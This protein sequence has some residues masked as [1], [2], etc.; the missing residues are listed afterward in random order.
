MFQKQLE[1]QNYSVESVTLGQRLYMKNNNGEMQSHH[2]K[3]YMNFILQDFNLDENRLGELFTLCWRPNLYKTYSSVN[4]SDLVKLNSKLINFENENSIRMFNQGLA[5]GSFLMFWAGLEAAQHCV[6][7]KLRTALGKPQ[8]TFTTIEGALKNLAREI[9]YGDSKEKGKKINLQNILNEHTRVRLLVEF[10]EHLEK[11]I[12]NAAEGC[13]V[14]LQPL[15]KPVRTFFHTNRSTCR[16]WL[17]RIRLA[18]CVVSLHAGLSTNVLR[19]GQ[20]LIEDLDKADNT[21][22]VEFE[23]AVLCTTQAMVRLGEAEALQGLYIYTKEK[24]RKFPWLKAAIEEAA[25]RYELAAESYKQILLDYFRE[26]SLTES[27][28]KNEAANCQVRK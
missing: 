6:Q 14:A 23:R 7:N 10:L 18:L 8:E 20:R 22:G 13:A 16:E 25:G 11:V 27:L 12:H 5:N 21:H 15:P 4:P 17:N 19:N 24:D 2:F 3:T 28:L 26:D 9:S 1:I